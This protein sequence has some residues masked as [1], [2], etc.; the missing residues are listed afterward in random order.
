MF[1]CLVQHGCTD[2]TSSTDPDR[3][4][5]AVIASGGF[6]DVR[7]V[8]LDNDTFV[9]VKTLRLHI[10]LK[11]DDKGVKVNLI[12]FLRLFLNLTVRIGT[13][14]RAVR[15]VYM[16]SKLH[17]PNVQE[18]LGIVVFQGSLGMVSPWMKEGNLQQFLTVHP[19]AER[20]SLVCRIRQLILLSSDS[21]SAFN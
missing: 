13:F 15:E 9:A 17:H 12:S 2:L 4:S 20:Y 1:D 7:R 11:D 19:E 3:H 14:Q 8:R 18:L 5:S 21:R 6:G 10:L 16:W